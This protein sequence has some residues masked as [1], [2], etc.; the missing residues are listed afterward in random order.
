[1]NS[2]QR[3]YTCTGFAVLFILMMLLLLGLLEFRL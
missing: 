3:S 2:V 1:M